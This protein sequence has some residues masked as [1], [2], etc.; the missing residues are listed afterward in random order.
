MEIN[1]GSIYLARANALAAPPE[2]CMICHGPAR[3]ADIK[4]M[5][6]KP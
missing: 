4:T 5:H 2:T 3:I 1:G 6:R